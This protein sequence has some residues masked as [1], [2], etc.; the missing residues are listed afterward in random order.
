MARGNSGAA[1]M[2][3]WLGLALIVSCG[4]V[5]SAFAVS[6]FASGFAAQ[7]SLAASASISGLDRP[8]SVNLVN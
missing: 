7:P 4:F 1:G 8:R 5:L 3:P 6:A 2:L